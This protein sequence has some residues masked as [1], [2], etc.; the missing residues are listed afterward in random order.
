M[1]EIDLT[2]A[3]EAGY[4]AASDQVGSSEVSAI[5]RAATPL[6]ERAVRAQIIADLR[7]KF[8]VTNRA[9]DYLARGRCLMTDRPDLTPAR[10]RTRLRLMK[11]QSDRLA[12]QGLLDPD[13]PTWA[14]HLADRAEA[15]ADFTPQDRALIRFQLGIRGGA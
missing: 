3:V 1:S 5:V 14:A 10:H 15:E 9:A 6:I 13:Q 11:E 2:A 4:E 7:A 8:G 12:D